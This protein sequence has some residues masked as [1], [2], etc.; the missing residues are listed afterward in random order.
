M[1]AKTYIENDLVTCGGL[2]SQICSDCNPWRPIF[3]EQLEGSHEPQE[4]PRG[5]RGTDCD[6]RRKIAQIWSSQDS[7]VCHHSLG[8]RYF[9]THTVVK[10]GYCSCQGGLNKQAKVNGIHHT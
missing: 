5:N 9:L 6:V 4:S 7:K 10:N 8:T 1:K 2:S 3:I